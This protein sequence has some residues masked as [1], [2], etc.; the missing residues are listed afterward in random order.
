ME[1]LYADD[2]V[3]LADTADLLIQKIRK[4]KTSMEEKGLRV[5]TGKTK[6]M[7]CQD[8]AS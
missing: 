8:R 6:V 1:L 4:W 2:L 7:R 5:N 3:L